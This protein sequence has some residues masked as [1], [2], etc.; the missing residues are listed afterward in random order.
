MQKLEKCYIQG[1]KEEDKE[2]VEIEEELREK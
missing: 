1:G 2:S